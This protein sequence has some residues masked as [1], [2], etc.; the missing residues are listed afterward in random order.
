MKKGFTLIE[1]MVTIIFLAIL[2]TMAL[3]SFSSYIDKTKAVAF[4]YSLNT[5]VKATRLKTNMTERTH[6]VQFDNKKCL[7]YKDNGDDSFDNADTLINS[8]KLEIP[9]SIELS[10]SNEKCKSD[11][12][13]FGYEK[14]W[15]PA[16]TISITSTK[17]EK[18]FKLTFPVGTDRCDFYEIVGNT[19]I[20]R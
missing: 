6:W 16:G 19:A 8:L 10:F 2:S 4:S 7:V 18:S 14:N 13:K 12:L 9:S 15:Y 5:I 11:G 3:I 1:L 17:I 20:L